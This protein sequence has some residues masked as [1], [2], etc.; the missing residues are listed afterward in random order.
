MSNISSCLIDKDVIKS[1]SV[2]LVI[3]RKWKLSC[4]DY[5]CHWKARSVLSYTD[6]PTHF[7]SLTYMTLLMVVVV[8]ALLFWSLVYLACKL[9]SGVLFA[10]SWGYSRKASVDLKV[11]EALGQFSE[12]CCLS[13]ASKCYHTE[14]VGALVFER[15]SVQCFKGC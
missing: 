14:L 3:Y 12:F 9:L 2:T 4:M 1:S 15:D 7:E 10:E 6:D 8:L 11:T 13:G 5:N